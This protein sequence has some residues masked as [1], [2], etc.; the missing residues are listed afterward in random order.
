MSPIARGEAHNGVPVVNE[1]LEELGLDAFRVYVTRKGRKG[2]QEDGDKAAS[3]LLHH[4]ALLIA[5]A[6]GSEM[7]SRGQKEGKGLRDGNLRLCET[8]EVIP[9]IV[10]QES[11]HPAKEHNRGM[12]GIDVVRLKDL[13]VRV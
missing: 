10:L 7:V 13:D 6:K 8:L 11:L 2:A 1:R 3:L 12:R 9:S 5:F 4:L